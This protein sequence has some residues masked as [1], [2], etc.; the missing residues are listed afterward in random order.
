[1]LL[2]VL[3]SHLRALDDFIT[4]RYVSWRAVPSFAD[5]VPLPR[6]HLVLITRLSP[7]DSR[8]AVGVP[9]IKDVKVATFAV[10]DGSWS[11]F[12]LRYGGVGYANKVGK[13]MTTWRG[14]PADDADRGR[15][16]PCTRPTAWEPCHLA[17]AV[18]AS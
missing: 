2:A 3:T 11:A 5:F 10:S 18:L 13:K 9:G 15:R 12:G 7:Q 16:R 17:A 6:H 14:L 4:Q 1:M 8:H